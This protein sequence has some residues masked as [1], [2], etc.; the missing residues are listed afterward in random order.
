MAAVLIYSPLIGEVYESGDKLYAYETGTT[1]QVTLYQDDDLSTAHTTPVV[2]DATGRFAAIYTDATGGDL[3][4]KV[5]DSDDVERFTVD[6]FIVNDLASITTS[7]ATLNTQYTSLNGRLTTAESEIDTLQTESADYESR[8]TQNETD[9]AT[10]EAADPSNFSETVLYNNLSAPTSGALTLSES[11]ETF[12]ALLF[13]ATFDTRTESRTPSFF[14]KGVL[15]TGG[16]FRCDVNK[17]GSNNAGIAF[18][19]TNATT[20]TVSDSSYTARIVRI[21]GLTF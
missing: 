12:D 15:D 4:I 14:T 17:G 1:T 9:I 16:T 2:A 13:I 18:T 11:W 7:V 8:I 3:K 10:L 20:V 21:V 6:P 19:M 5:T